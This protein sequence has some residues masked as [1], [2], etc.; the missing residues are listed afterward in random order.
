VTAN[1]ELNRIESNQIKSNQIKSNQIESTQLKRDKQTIM[2]AGTVPSSSS[3]SSILYCDE[4]KCVG[5]CSS[6]SGN[7]G[8]EMTCYGD[9]NYHPYMCSDGYIPKMVKN[10]PPI[11][12]KIIDTDYRLEMDIVCNYYTCCATSSSTNTNNTSPVNPEE[13]DDNSFIIP[14][15]HCSNPYIGFDAIIEEADKATASSTI[16]PMKIGKHMNTGELIE[17]YIA[18]N[19]S[20]IF[21]KNNETGVYNNIDNI[22][23]INTDT[24]NRNYLDDIDCEP[25]SDKYY[26]ET[27]TKNVYGYLSAMTCDDLESGFIYPEPIVNKLNVWKDYSHYECCKTLPSIIAAGRSA[28]SSPMRIQYFIQDNAIKITKYPQIIISAL[29]ICSCIFLIIGMIIPLC[30]K[31]FKSSNNGNRTSSSRV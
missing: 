29:A 19:T 6:L 25:Y 10:E 20:H 23:N 22:N 21:A 2:S 28:T 17:S 5:R 8:G 9:G 31:L 13:K 7:G 12:T 4:S 26:A 3:S 30:M 24:N 1:V 11:K 27:R 18:C 14:T 15:R 16:L